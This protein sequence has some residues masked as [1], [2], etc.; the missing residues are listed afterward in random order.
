MPTGH[1][2]RSHSH[3]TPLE[4]YSPHLFL[5]SYPSPGSNGSHPASVPMVP[6]HGAPQPYH[7]QWIYGDPEMDYYQQVHHHLHQQ[8]YAPTGHHHHHVYDRAHRRRKTERSSAG[9]SASER[10]MKHSSGTRASKRA[11]A[12]SDIEKTYTGLDRELA[13]EFI[14]QT[15]DPNA[16]LERNKSAASSSAAHHGK[17]PSPS[18]PTSPQAFNYNVK[19]ASPVVI[20]AATVMPM[21]GAESEGAW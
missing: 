5:A 4:I 12:E 21:S 20:D 13:E 16:L 3:F 11:P 14:E 1:S 18:S 6:V 17:S 15:M 7:Q 10:R 19:T 8:Y 9:R 2:A